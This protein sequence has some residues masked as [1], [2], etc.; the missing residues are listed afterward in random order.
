MGGWTRP[1]P[2]VALSFAEVDHV[3]GHSV[4]ACGRRAP[5]APPRAGRP[6]STREI[7]RS[8]RRPGRMRLSGEGRPRGVAQHPHLPVRRPRQGRGYG[9]ADEGPRLCSAHSSLPISS[10]PPALCRGGR[11][12]PAR[13]GGDGIRVG[14]RLPEA[15]LEPLGGPNDNRPPSSR[16]AT[17]PGGIVPPL[18]RKHDESK[19]GGVAPSSASG[20]RSIRPRTSRRRLVGASSRGAVLDA[21]SPLRGGVTISHPPRPAPGPARMRQ[22]RRGRRR[23]TPPRSPARAIRGDRSPDGRAPRG[24]PP[25]PGGFSRR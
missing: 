11:G 15:G 7:E 22:P 14:V 8:T 18:S 3:G 17:Q 23:S 25:S 5:P 9:T 21:A 4:A 13:V 12:P 1:E 24:G 16:R 10:A 19:S 6:G 2:C 20:R